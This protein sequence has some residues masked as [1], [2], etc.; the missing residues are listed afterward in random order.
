MWD[1]AIITM[2]IQLPIILRK[3]NRWLGIVGSLH[4]ITRRDLTLD[5]EL[6]KFM[7]KNKIK[8]YKKT[9]NVFS[10]TKQL[11]LRAEYRKVSF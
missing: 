1:T 2:I 8:K 4:M 3:I 6:Q 7:F 11:C 10:T 5:N 9:T